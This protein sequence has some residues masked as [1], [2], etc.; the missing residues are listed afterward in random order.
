MSNA[1]AAV[2]GEIDLKITKERSILPLVKVMP[3]D[4]L[5]HMFS[6]HE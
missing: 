6:G 5:Y 3:F 2:H 1:S 4:T